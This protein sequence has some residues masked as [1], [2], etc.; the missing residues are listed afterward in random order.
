MVK[1]L[2]L[3]PQLKTQFFDK[4]AWTMFDNKVWQY[5]GMGLFILAIVIFLIVLG[6]RMLTKR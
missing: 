3:L 5:L 1:T 2:V 6:I 4:P